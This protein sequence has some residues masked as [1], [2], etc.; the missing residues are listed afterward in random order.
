MSKSPV[1]SLMLLKNICFMSFNE[2]KKKEKTWLS[3]VVLFVVYILSVK[4][5]LIPDY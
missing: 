3:Q 1:N 4:P 2:R 5:T